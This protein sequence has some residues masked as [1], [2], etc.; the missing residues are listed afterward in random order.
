MKLREQLKQRKKLVKVKEHLKKYK[1]EYIIGGVC[2]TAGVVIGVVVS[3]SDSIKIGNNGIAIGSKIITTDVNLTR[4]GH[5]GNVIK[6]NETGE[7]FASQRRAAQA[8]GLSNIELYN[9]LAGRA[10]KAKGYT[11]EKLGEAS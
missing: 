2:I 5:P 8:M 10:E 6:C 1:K 3:K 7:I 9:Q 4:R 11:F